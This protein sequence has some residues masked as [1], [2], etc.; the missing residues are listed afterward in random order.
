MHGDGVYKYSNNASVPQWS[1]L[2][3]NSR[4]RATR[5][6]ITNFHLTCLDWG[7]GWHVSGRSAIN[8]HGLCHKHT[9]C[10]V[11]D[12]NIAS[13]NTLFLDNRGRRCR[14]FLSGKSRT[15]W[16]IGAK[17]QLSICLKLNWTIC[18]KLNLRRDKT[19]N[20]WGVCAVG[21]CSRWHFCFISLLESHATVRCCQAWHQKTGWVVYNKVLFTRARVFPSMG[22]LWLCSHVQ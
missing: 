12:P 3:C 21:Y 8:H 1:A 10:V 4:S 22:L 11:C 7:V 2:A 20:A 16:S 9:L 14:A 5:S 17:C 18:L 6:W 19:V 15:F 13:Q